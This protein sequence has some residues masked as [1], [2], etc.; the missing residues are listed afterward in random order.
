[1]GLHSWR[2]T[3]P[4]LPRILHYA[5]MFNSFII[6][7]NVIITVIKC[8]I[9]LMLLNHPKTIPPHPTPWKNYLPWN[10]SLVPDRLGTADLHYQLEYA[11]KLY[12]S[13]QKEK[14]RYPRKS[15]KK[16][17]S[18]FA[19][20]KNQIFYVKVNDI[21]TFQSSDKSNLNKIQIYT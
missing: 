19:E 1:M 11:T 12:K 3:S 9:N 14:S 20:R 8:T 4:G 16:I 17:W 5:E 7:H 10:R 6:Y 15:K 18:H 21:Q 13:N 2:T